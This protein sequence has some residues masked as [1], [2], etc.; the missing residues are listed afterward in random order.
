MAQ[1]VAQTERLVAASPQHVR[2]FL[3]TTGTTVPVSCRQSTSETI[4]WSKA[5][6]E[7]AP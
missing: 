2:A 3:S 1:V 6:S 5:E 4:E 7:Q